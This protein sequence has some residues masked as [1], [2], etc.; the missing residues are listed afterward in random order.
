MLTLSFFAL[1]AII[2][3]PNASA[4]TTS[5]NVGVFWDSAATKD[6][7]AT[8]I[9]W[10]NVSVGTA[11]EV[12]VYVK[13]L[14]QQPLILSMNTSAWN[15]TT[16]SLKMFMLWNY[17]DNPIAAGSVIKLN[18]RLYVSPDISGVTNFSFNV[19]IGVGLQKSFDLNGDGAID[20]GDVALFALTWGSE[21][22]S[23][24]YNYRCDFDNDGSVDIGDA[25]AM[26]I[27][28]G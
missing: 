4:V 8:G 23:P 7:T 14:G 1:R 19:N 2:A 12:T 25:S 20:I 17:D 22:S 6:V 13:N 26:A 5:G 16:A 10:G 27:A 3:V 15:P 11:A 18:L 24:N 9:K 28:I 21:V